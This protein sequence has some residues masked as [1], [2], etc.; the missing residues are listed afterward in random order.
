MEKEIKTIRAIYRMHCAEA[1]NARRDIYARLDA[2]EASTDT[3]E[4]ARIDREIKERN[5]TLEYHNLRKHILRDALDAL[6]G[7]ERLNNAE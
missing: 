6:E 1:N 5:K 3:E 4:R 7:Y 2:R